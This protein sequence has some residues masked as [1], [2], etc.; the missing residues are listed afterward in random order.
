M[1]LPKIGVLDNT[2]VY[3]NGVYFCFCWE[4]LKND[5]AACVEVWTWVWESPA[6]GVGNGFTDYG[7]YF[8]YSD[9]DCDF[10]YDWD[11]K[12][13]IFGD[14]KNPWLIGFLFL[15]YWVCT[16]FKFFYRTF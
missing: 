15:S 9:W 13:G 10:D 14:V 5:G 6:N 2:G 3:V 12:F 16:I 4:E 8:Y 7:F 11:C 1:K